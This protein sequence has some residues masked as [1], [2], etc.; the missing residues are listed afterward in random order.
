MALRYFIVLFPL[1]VIIAM[2]LNYPTRTDIPEWKDTLYT[3]LINSVG[4]WLCCLINILVAYSRPYNGLFFS[5]F[6]CS[7]HMVTVVPLTVYLNRKLYLYHI[8][9]STT[10]IG[11]QPHGRG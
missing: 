11:P 4:I 5:S 3:V 8:S 2:G 9:Q 6:I 7:Y 1:Y 10:S